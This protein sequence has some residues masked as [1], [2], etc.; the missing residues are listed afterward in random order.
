MGFN[1]G[2]KGLTDHPNTPKILTA[3]LNKHLINIIIQ[4]A[5]E[6]I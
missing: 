3:S 1:S 6:V 4:A 5:G 2:F